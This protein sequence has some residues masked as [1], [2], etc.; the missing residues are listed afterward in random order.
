MESSRNTESSLKRQRNE[1]VRRLNQI[2]VKKSSLMTNHKHHHHHHHHRKKSRPRQ[3]EIHA[4]RGDHVKQVAH[5]DV[6]EW[7]ERVQTIELE[8]KDTTHSQCRKR[9]LRRRSEDVGIDVYRNQNGIGRTHSRCDLYLTLAA[10]YLVLICSIA[11]TTN[12]D[13]STA[14]S[15]SRTAVL[16]LSSLSLVLTSTLGIRCV[17]KSACGIIT[18]KH[19]SPKPPRRFTLEHMTTPIISMFTYIASGMILYPRYDNDVISAEAA[20]TEIEVW[21]ANLFYFSYICLYGSTYLM[22]K[23]FVQNDTIASA[24]SSIKILLSMAL[25]SSMCNTIAIMVMKHGPACYGYLDQYCSHAAT[26]EVLG[27]WCIFMSLLLCVATGCLELYHFSSTSRRETRLRRSSAGMRNLQRSR[28]LLYMILI[29]GSTLLFILHCANVATV[30]SSSRGS[31]GSAFITSWVACIISLL[32]WKSSVVEF[33]NYIHSKALPMPFGMNK[34]DTTAENE[35]ERSIIE[36]SERSSFTDST[37]EEL[38]SDLESPLPPIGDTFVLLPVQQKTRVQNEERFAKNSSRQR[39]YRKAPTNETILHVQRRPDPIERLV[40]EELGSGDNIDQNS[41]RHL[42]AAQDDHLK[43]NEDLS[44]HDSYPKVVVPREKIHTSR[45]NLD[46]VGASSSSSFAHSTSTGFVQKSSPDNPCR[47][48]NDQPKSTEDLSSH[49]SDP[50]SVIPR[51]KN[52]SSN[53]ERAGASPLPYAYSTP[54]S[55][56]FVRRSSIQSFKSNLSPLHEGSLESSSRTGTT[57]SIKNPTL[58]PSPSNNLIRLS[59][60]RKGRITKSNSLRMN[61]DDKQLKSHIVVTRTA[62]PPPPPPRR[63]INKNQRQGG[64]NDKILRETSSTSPNLNDP[65][66]NQLLTKKKSKSFDCRLLS[67]TNTH[68]IQVPENHGYS[69]ESDFI[70]SDIEVIL[71]GGNSVVTELS[72][73]TAKARESDS[74]TPLLMKSLLSVD[75]ISAIHEAAVS[76]NKK[77]RIDSTIKEWETSI[78]STDEF[79]ASSIL[80]SSQ[81]SAKHQSQRRGSVDS[82][83]SMKEALAFLHK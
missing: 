46:G 65:S 62:T 79:L 73:G 48:Q 64:T 37:F 13:Y 67:T 11:S 57:G 59:P 36:C 63:N 32:L 70:M 33:M 41:R 29:G 81:N 69:I 40:S 76:A 12:K 42:V 5:Q 1:H 26:A 3:Q 78:R 60:S 38:Y 35:N 56:G 61:K 51:E 22:L 43:S 68:Q 21:N 18:T 17:Y 49:D 55:T 75:V 7:G 19:A 14:R 72:E 58:V 39:K 71:S 34:R 15:S 50:K 44:S 80:N 9:S 31:D 74:H 54:I 77:K 27:V 30:T 16:I 24:L 28:T 47:H 20:V 83:S 6:N 25:F 23:V 52:H 82:L 8:L 66:A 4:E 10:A 2:E 45:R 53:L